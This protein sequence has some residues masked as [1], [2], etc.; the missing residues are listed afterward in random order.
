MRDDLVMTC[1]AGK[2]LSV[3]DRLN[4]DQSR[5]LLDVLGWR[6]WCLRICLPRL[7]LWPPIRW[8]FA[9]P[10]MGKRLLCANLWGRIPSAVG[11]LSFPI[12]DGT[13]SQ[14]S[15]GYPVGVGRATLVLKQKPPEGAG[16]MG[17]V[18]YRPAVLTITHIAYR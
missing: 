2:S 18:L 7:Y 8:T 3:P 9:K 10:L 1:S 11:S 5:Q 12:A 4:P 14:F 15:S 17:C 13:A 16:A 6:S